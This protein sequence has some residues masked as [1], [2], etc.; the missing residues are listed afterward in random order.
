MKHLAKTSSAVAL[1]ACTIS[2]I[3][4]WKLHEA[5][6]QIAKL[7]SQNLEEAKIVSALPRGNLSTGSVEIDQHAPVPDSKDK[8]EAVLIEAFTSGD[9][10]RSEDSIEYLHALRE[11]TRL[12]LMTRYHDLAEEM[13]LR[14]GEASMVFAILTETRNLTIKRASADIRSEQERITALLGTAGYEK[15][16]EY[17]RNLPFRKSVGQI[18]AVLSSNGEKPLNT[19]QVR[20]LVSAMAAGSVRPNAELSQAATTFNSSDPDSVRTFR[21]VQLRVEME[22]ARQISAQAASLLT[23]EQLAALDDVLTE[24]SRTDLMRRSLRKEQN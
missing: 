23:R 18:Q 12:S 24:P 16:R 15:W 19:E 2:V 17:E 10:N 11:S 20:F 3:L 9:A 14:P 5:N 13:N 21:E 4:S 1:M 6:R 8:E 22:K 7:Q